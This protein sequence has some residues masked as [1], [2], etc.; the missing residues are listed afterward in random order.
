MLLKE[1]SEAIGVSGA[2]DEVRDVILKAIQ[3]YVEDI[4]IDPMGSILAVKRGS[5]RRRKALRVMVA[6]HMD[7]VGFMV[8]GIEASGA[9]R[10]APVGGFDPRLLPGLRVVIGKDRVPA[11]FDW[12]PIH[13]NR[14]Q[15]VVPLDRLR[16]DIGATSKEQANGRVRLGDRA[17]FDTR[18]RE[19]GRFAFGKAFDDR[20]GCAVLIDLLQGDPLPYDLHVAF[21]VQEEVGLRGALV[22]AQTIKPDVAFILEGTTA[23]DLPPVDDD[24]ET[25][26]VSPSTE[27]GK[28]PALTLADNTII[29][30]RR[31][32]THLRKTAEAAGIPYQ[33]RRSMAGGTDAGAVFLANGGI[34]AAVISTPCR[35][36]HGP[37]AVCRLDDLENVARLLRAALERLT[38]TVMAR[39]AEME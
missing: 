30:D 23:H 11:V 9:I 20:A 17:T 35:Y 3:G 22:A 39:P 33:Y 38:P 28:G 15:S 32:L 36:I 14:E 16:L 24:P 25:P 2:E 18:Y 8:M 13:L 4:R 27:L 19:Q 37:T 5:N 34:P 21:T 1:L 6:A 7:E 12:K 31:L 10:V 29:V 26:Q